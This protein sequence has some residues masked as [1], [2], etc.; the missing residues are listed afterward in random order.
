MDWA[1]V[2]FIN[3][4]DEAYSER[5]QAKYLSPWSNTTAGTDVQAVSFWTTFQDWI[6]TYC[7][8]FVQSHDA[9]GS[10]RA[11]NCY[12]GE[13][14]MPGWT[15]ANLMESASGGAAGAGQKHFRRATTIPTDW[16]NWTDAAY[17]YGQMQAG[18]IIGPWIFKD[19]QE[20][21]RRL[22]WSFGS[23]NFS[24]LQTDNRQ[25]GQ[26]NDADWATAKSEAEDNTYIT[27]IV[28]EPTAYTYASA[29]EDY[30]TRYTAAFRAIWNKGIASGIWTGKVHSIDFYI[31]PVKLTAAHPW[32]A[33]GLGLTQ[34]VLNLFESHLL[35]SS[36]TETSAAIGHNNWAGQGYTWCACPVLG[37]GD[38]KRGWRTGA[39][40]VVLRWDVT[41]GFDYT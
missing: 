24:G 27:S 28:H 4:F 41:G 14:A 40:G 12:D 29:Y 38:T 7:T 30:G 5:R 10:I 36:A 15:I 32:D 34:D 19:L 17:S 18:D 9:D 21:F 37:G 35:S 16:T 31:M 20:A 23:C 13:T 11:W 3:E 6:T 25:R 33:Y 1:A 22:I 39:A 26:G 2:S 8:G